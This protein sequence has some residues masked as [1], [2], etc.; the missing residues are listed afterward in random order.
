MFNGVAHPVIK[1]RLN[2]LIPNNKQNMSKVVLKSCIMSYASKDL[3]NVSLNGT[4]MGSGTTSLER[5][6]VSQ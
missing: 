4:K 6:G 2:F 3:N 1:I 5:T